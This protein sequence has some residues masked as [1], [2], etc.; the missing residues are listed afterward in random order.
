MYGIIASAIVTAATSIALV[1]RLQVKSVT[2]EVIAIPPKQ[3]GSGI[4][5][6]AGGIIFGLGWALTGACPGHY[7]RLSATGFP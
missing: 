5:Y 3:L 4:R 7:S 2:G 1:E 6:A